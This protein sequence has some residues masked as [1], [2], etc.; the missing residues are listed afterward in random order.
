MFSSGTGYITSST[1]H[2][3]VWGSNTWTDVG[4]VVGPVGP[5]GVQGPQ[6]IQGPTGPSGPSGPRG[7]PGSSVTIFGTTAT[8][9][10]L[11][12][13]TGLSSGTGYITSNT[14]HLWVW[15][16][17]T[18]TDV[19]NVVGPLGPQ[20][21]Q[22]PQGPQGPQGVQ[23][24]S[25]P[26]GP[27]ISSA[28]VTSFGTLTLF[29]SNNTTVTVAGSILGP[30]GPIGVQGFRGPQ[31]PTGPVIASA[32]VTSFGTLTLFL[33]DNSTVTVAGSVFGPSGPS[34]PPGPSG[35]PSGPSGPAGPSGPSGTPGV[36]SATIVNDVVFL[37][38]TSA[39]ST[40]TGAL[41]VRGGVGIG[42]NLYTK[43]NLV[44]DSIVYSSYY[45]N[46]QTGL[47]GVLVTGTNIVNLTSGTTVN[48]VPG[49][50]IMPSY[51][52]PAKPGRFNLSIR[53]TEIKEIISATQFTVY[54]NHTVGGALNFEYGHGYFGAGGTVYGQKG[55]VK[56]GTYMGNDA[57]I[58]A[59]GG[60]VILQPYTDYYT[61]NP[62][63]YISQNVGLEIVPSNI[64]FGP[65][66][67]YFNI[68][69][70][71]IDGNVT[72]P[73]DVYF[74][75]NGNGRVVV[76][77]SRTATAGGAAALQVIG[78]V[79]VGDNLR[80][81]NG[82]IVS[83][84][85]TVTNTTSATSTLTGAL[86]VSGGVGVRGTVWANDLRQDSNQVRIG[87]LAGQ[88]TQ[89]IF[90]VALGASAGQDS[91]G[92]NTVAIGRNAGQTN[93]LSLA[94]A[95][96]YG[97]GNTGQQLGAVALGGDAGNS[98]QGQYSVALG[99]SAGYQNQ[100]TATIVINATGAALNTQGQGR[101]YVS[102][103]RND[104]STS[105][106]SYE[107]YYNPVTNEITSSTSANLQTITSRGSSTN[108][109]V[110]LTNT[111]AASSTQTGALVVSG[112]VGIGGNLYVGGDIV[113]QRVTIQ[114][115]TITNAIIQTDDTIQTYNT[116][117][118]TSTTTGALLV[119]GGVG[120]GGSVY[121]KN[122][123]GYV[124][125]SGV[126]RV[127]QYYNPTTDSLDT[128]FE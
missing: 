35:G 76:N 121:V 58:S 100:H 27:T 59:R 70:T 61:G 106:T 109:V 127:Y 81:T 23:G 45:P 34:G 49:M 44:S 107:L 5:Q 26:T 31:G 25:G 22:G 78:G 21:V 41:Q 38:T 54:F 90:A 42:G 120:V 89:S 65:T 97:A 11:P 67:A 98:N 116:S 118:S 99:S 108:L 12:Y 82:V 93:Q 47:S 71:A 60:N 52:D 28:T 112:G 95:I 96:G 87:Y 110:S 72:S 10:G 68:G 14:G 19:G 50:V 119:A 57:F 105:G 83:G 51:N 125:T 84:I 69:L 6:G 56:Y 37:S 124:N 66:T 122:R 128:V 123:V 30:Q 13:P 32:T 101:F 39:T 92:Q 86:Q 75:M 111:T 15:A 114:F 115:T 79:S 88:N 20:G 104:V 91:Q 33:S 3:W 126:S 2:L 17:N 9:A 8:Q 85:T 36:V 102:P 46:Y 1:G 74:N 43:G 62:S 77:S 48:W 18:W 94:V 64:I 80:V 29:L 55:N 103:I 40:L 7:D 24:P 53:S 113:A 63:E 4:T 73:G 16:S 117:S